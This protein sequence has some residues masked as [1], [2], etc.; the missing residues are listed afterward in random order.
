VILDIEGTTTPL[1]FVL[2]TLFPYS[3]QRLPRWIEENVSEA[4]WM[5]LKGASS[6]R[7]ANPQAA[8]P[9]TPVFAAAAQAAMASGQPDLLTSLASL[10]HGLTQHLM[11]LQ[12]VN[13]KVPYLKQMQGWIWE[14]GYRRKELMGLM[15]DDVPVC[16]R[17]L[18]A[19]ADS[20]NSSSPQNIS[21]SSIHIYSS[22]SVHAQK[23]IFGFTRYGDLNRYVSGYD[24][25]AT[26]GSKL[27]AVSYRKNI[28]NVQQRRRLMDGKPFAK[29]EDDAGTIVSVFVSDNIDEL[30]AASEAGML[31][32]WCVRP[33]NAPVEASR[34]KELADGFKGKERKQQQP[35]LTVSSFDVITFVVQS[36]FSAVAQDR[37]V[38]P[39]VRATMASRRSGL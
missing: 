3:V 11:E 39:Y 31:A 29:A 5:A 19:S 20:G 23:L 15:F 22:G 27:E 12:R 4:V 25:T 7:G 24:D 18:A 10:R 35:L 32:V 28:D 36:L 30:R 13:S 9:K 2:E 37:I 34:L 21:N 16:F 1:P 17:T 14:D 8:D 33:L 6:S 38:A 26:V